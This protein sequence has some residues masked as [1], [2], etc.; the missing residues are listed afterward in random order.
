MQTIRRARSGA[1]T[2]LMQPSNV[3]GLKGM[4]SPISA[5]SRSPSTSLS[6]A[7]S[8][9]GAQRRAQRTAAALP[10]GRGCGGTLTQHGAADVHPDPAVPLLGDVL[11]AQ[12][13]AAAA[14]GRGTTAVRG[15]LPGRPHPARRA[16]RAAHPTSRRRHGRPSGSASNSTARAAICAWISATR[17]LRGEGGGSAEAL[18]H[19]R[20]PQHAP[21]PQPTPV[22]PPAVLL[23]VFPRLRLIVELQQQKGGRR[24][25]GPG[26]ENR[27]DPTRS[28]RTSSGGPRCSGRRPLL[29][30]LCDDVTTRRRVPAERL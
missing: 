13:G 24:E 7:T 9:Q 11:P 5:R 27:P 4:P 12:S 6:T 19:T 17:E 28:A 14:H 21:G 25:R 20:S 22:P 8:V 23:S 16:P 15:V 2:H 1:Q 29:A 10:A 3:P 30:M 26:P 18:R